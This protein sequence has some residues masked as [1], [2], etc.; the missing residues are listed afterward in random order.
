MANPITFTGL[1]SGIDLA[2]IVSALVQTERQ[3]Y[4]EPF[5]N[6]KTEW[7]DKI[8]AFQDLNTKLASFHTSVKAL[9]SSSEFLV[10]TAST[11]GCLPSSDISGLRA[12]YFF[13]VQGM[14]DVTKI[15]AGSISRVSA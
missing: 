14:I 10:K 8:A 11:S 4:I 15:F 1:G 13:A 9:D 3:R 2:S 5:E 12:S 6:W 7:E